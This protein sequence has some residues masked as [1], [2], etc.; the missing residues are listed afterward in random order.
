MIKN[1]IFLICYTD[2]IN[3]L[4]FEVIETS[5]QQKSNIFYKPKN[6]HMWLMLRICCIYVFADCALAFAYKCLQNH[7]L[8]TKAGNSFE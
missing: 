2:K 4:R 8:C 6:T 3:L 1:I 7:F 5:I